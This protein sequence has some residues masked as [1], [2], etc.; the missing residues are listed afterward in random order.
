MQYSVRDFV[1]I[2]CNELGINIQWE[3]EGLD[4]RGF[5]RST[6]KEIV[7]VDPRYFRPAEVEILLG[8][9][10]KAR[11]KLGWVPRTSFNEMVTEMVVHDL[12]EAEKDVLCRD[13]GFSTFNYHE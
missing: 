10:S 12:Q 13:E 8:D 7:A 9:S 3:R 4:E 11:E 2:A 5:D 6:G 1:N